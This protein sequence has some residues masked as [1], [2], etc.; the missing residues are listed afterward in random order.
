VGIYLSAHP[1]DEYKIVLDNLCNTKC[2]ELADV[3][4]LKDRTDVIIGGIVTA[5]RTRFDKRGN[6][7]G[8]VTLEDFEGSGE[9]ALF[10]DDWGRYSGMFT[11]G[12]AVYVSAKLQPRFQ[13][14]DILGLKVQDIQYL[15]TV[16]E[17]SIDRIT[18]SLVS[19]MLDEQVVAELSEIIS[20]NPGKTK[21]FFLLRD[22][23]SKNHVLLRAQNGGVDVRH[24]LIDYIDSHE[25]IDYK[26]N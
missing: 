18:I 23:Q 10:G 16:K 5:I 4:Q 22:S 24:T 15:S 25:M 11:E 9:L 12:A 1:L 7:C 14:S 6:P 26:I 17:K 20:E 2:A 21:L 19:D 13:H 8:F 3:N